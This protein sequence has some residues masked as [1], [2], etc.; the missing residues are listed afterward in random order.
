M[1]LRCLPFLLF[2]SVLFL[3]ASAQNDVPAAT[4][5]EIELSISKRKNLSDI[6]DTVYG[7]K[8]KA[9]AQKNDALLGRCLYYEM[10]ITDRRTE[11]TLY[12]K[13][14]RY[15]DSI[16]AAPSATLLLKT[17]MHL[18]KAERIAGFTKKQYLQQNKNLYASYNSRYQ[19]NSM[20]PGE[21]DSLVQFHCKEALILNE[22]SA[23]TDVKDL[24]W[25]AYDPL[26]FL[27]KPGFA[28]IILASQIRYAQGSG[29]PV[30]ST[31]AMDSLLLLSPDALISS[32][33]NT[34]AFSAAG[35]RVFRL[36]K[37][38]IHYQL[39][40]NKAA[41]YFVETLLRKFIYNNGTK[42]NNAQR[43]YESYLQG[44]SES[45]YSAA[46]AHG[47]YQLCLL[48]IGHARRYNP[49]SGQYYYNNN[50]NYFDS[51]Y[52]KHYLKAE[53]LFTRNEQL[54]DSIS[55]LKTLLVA[56][57]E[58][59]RLKEMSLSLRQSP[60]PDAPLLASLTYRNTPQLFVRLVKVNAFKINYNISKRKNFLTDSLLNLPVY[61]SFNHSLPL[62][63]DHQ[64]HHTLL[65]ISG[66]TAGEYFLLYSDTALVKGNRR[67]ELQ[68]IQVSNTVTINNEQRVFVLHKKTGF[69]I[70]GAKV[71]VEYDAVRNKYTNDIERLSASAVKTV[72]QQGFVTVKEEDVYALRIIN[73]NDSLRCFINDPPNDDN[74]VSAYSKEEGDDLAEF[75][76]DEMKIQLFTD[77]SIYRPGQTVQ[78]KGIL[79]TKNR[80]TGERMIANWK[81]MKMPFFQKKTFKKELLSKEDG[82]EIYLKDA[83]NKTMDTIHIV[84]NEYGSFTGKYNIP[85]NAATGEWD[86]DGND[87]SLEYPNYGRFKVEEYKRPTFELSIKSPD[88]HLTAGDDFEAKVMVKSFAGASLNKVKISYSVSRNARIPVYD[89]I[90]KTYKEQYFEHEIIND[91]IGY[92]NEKGELLIAITDTAVRVNRLSNNSKWDVFYS[93]SAEA[94]D[95]TGETHEEEKRIT[96]SN[97]PVDIF[98]NLP[99]I[100]DRKDI[101]PIYVSTKSAFGGL[102]PKA[103]QVKLYRAKEQKEKLQPTRWPIADVW[104]AEKETLQ[105]LFPDTDFSNGKKEEEEEEKPA[106]IFTTTLQ[107]GGEDKLVLP[108]ALMQAGEYTIEMVCIENGLITGNNT[109]NF[110]VFDK[111]NNQLPGASSIF[112]YMNLNTVAKDGTIRWVTGNAKADIYSIYHI[113][114]CK[115]KRK[116]ISIAYEY[117]MRPEKKGVHEWTHTMPNSFGDSYALLTHCFVLNN[118]LYT[119]EQR[120]YTPSD[121]NTPEITVEQYRTR[122][123]PGGKETFT[124]SVKT[125]NKSTASELMTTMYDAALDKLS[126]HEW[127]LPRAFSEPTIRT[128]WEYDING[129]STSRLYTDYEAQYNFQSS[130]NM[131]S[132]WWLQ[133]MNISLTESRHL[134]LSDE[135]QQGLDQVLLAR[136]SGVSITSSAGLDEVVVTGYGT[137]KSKAVTAS[138]ILIRGSSSLGAFRNLPLVILDGVPFTGDLSSINVNSITAAIVL[139]GADATAIY[140]AKATGG[141]LVLSTKG[142]I[143]LPE[144]EAPPVVIRK[145]FSET[146]FFFPQV[147][148]DA[149]GYY[150]ISFTMPE[151]VTEWK[152]KLLSHTK[153]ARFAYTDRSIF[154]QLPLMVQPN[155]PRFLYAGDKVLLQ[156]RITNLDTSHLTGKLNC[157]VEDAETGE[158]IT[159]KIVTEPQQNFSINRSSNTTAGFFLQIP[160]NILHPLR[161]KITGKAGNFGD[162]EEH[163]IP[164]LQKKILV[165]QQ[166]PFVLTISG[167]TILKAPVLP[168]DATPYGLGLFINPKPQSAL[169]NALPYLAFYPYNCAEQTFNK[170]FAHSVATKI[171]RTDT[172]AQNAFRRM[173]TIDKTGNEAMPDEMSE[174]TMPWLN[175]SHTTAIHQRKLA[176]L[177]DTINGNDQLFTYF[178][179]LRDL[180]KQDGGITWFKGGESSSYISNYILAGFGK[181]LH[182]ELPFL[183]NSDMQQHIKTFIPRLIKFC[184]EDQET[185]GSL[186]RDANNPVFFLFARSYWLKA[187]PLSN[188][189]QQKA[190][191][192]LK[193]S[194]TNIN[195][196]ALGRQA[197]IIL[198]TLR[199]ASPGTAL[200]QLAL[201]QLNSIEQ[202]A[203]SDQVNGVRWKG[204]S[205]EDDLN[206]NSEE[207]VI[208]LAEAFEASGRSAATV[209]GIIKW[210]LHTR[211]DHNWSTT[212]ST[213]DA[214]ALLHRRQPVITGLPVQLS[215]NTGGAGLT[216]SDN[217]FAGRF[218]AFHPQQ[219]FSGEIKVSKDNLPV[220][221][222]GGLTYYYFT[223]NPPLAQPDGTVTVS[224]QL[225]RFNKE[226]N[227]W[228][229]ITNSTTLQI[230]DKIK[231]VITIN[232]PK[233]L[234]Y[235]LIDERRAAAL[236]PADV[237][238]GY[239][240]GN[241][242]SYYQSVRDIGYQFFAEQVPAG[243]SSL[244]YE[245]VVASEGQFTNGPVSLQCMYKPAIRAYSGSVELNIPA[246][247]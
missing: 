242:F 138:S 191:S 184:D 92:T 187:Y 145:N 95:G 94:T 51:S 121:N 90:T 42:N 38:W 102:I 163:I 64:Q 108:P 52:R 2:F 225:F 59:I 157:I 203:I 136:A 218:F 100:T 159:G 162:G 222:P 104:L 18:L 81:N 53:A 118:Q 54:F 56:M 134:Y 237:N 129:S 75:Y 143:R 72:N 63:D 154:T 109:K 204:I 206:T 193:K 210:L 240:Y 169:V 20:L 88:K 115:K 74:P 65:P 177:L 139:K 173:N 32:T 176:K 130:N 112:H 123:A 113:A 14:A 195:D 28:D 23:Q 27:F 216:V 78:F 101:A 140:G 107:A 16:L 61:R 5:K 192:I 86:F 215:L 22:Q 9:I 93:I 25:L 69:P 135:E 39:P 110:T 7:I 46:K 125:N 21:L 153:D 246:R 196:Y 1:L 207:Q 239:Q 98:F 245:T 168:A 111:A 213:A 141:V 230:A 227:T 66:L 221:A 161:V 178:N 31:V 49:F 217:M 200:H 182:D 117:D 164:I 105:S 149:K 36:Y 197:M 236:E 80:L 44:I 155:T 234:K 57:K 127:R 35:K 82:L 209:E 171:M 247:R 223:A 244:S 186:K 220:N 58:K 8:Q 214:V 226:T 15:M 17:I 144:P 89:S 181:L 160:G 48:W 243:I 183:V 150:H 40:R 128:Q 79:F 67:I 76:Q 151:S 190:D 235:V 199:Y 188:N 45:A 70:A 99:K 146:A 205:D 232:A 233:Q 4:W 34:T 33:N 185:G 180:Q 19:Y 165:S 29:S 179:L 158:D 83:F 137:V 241:G 198:A 224:K 97:Y 238:S 212:K 211:Q 37:E 122:L 116:G 175:L 26:L 208:K 73:G 50:Y 132:V 12:F 174:A 219:S 10:Q 55:F 60:M 41:A 103:L 147:Y 126:K 62:A 3:Y 148:A 119:E 77:R 152:W 43:Y 120:L 84:P 114:Y 170:L 229:A 166:V 194:F 13:N 87:F 133:E 201:K 6:L 142:A 228:D 156:T 47:I 189:L 172:A 68:K 71:V 167:D 85:K 231:T 106:P 30:W 124:M 24:V 202:L 11:D 131:P 96:L 91:T